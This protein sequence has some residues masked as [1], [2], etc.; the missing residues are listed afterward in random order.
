MRGD[1]HGI[2]S[3][4][5]NHD[6]QNSFPVLSSYEP[7]ELFG[8]IAER[9]KEAV[10]VSFYGAKAGAGCGVLLQ[11]GCMVSALGLPLPKR[12]S[13]SLQQF[14][15]PPALLIQLPP[16]T[17]SGV[18]SSCGNSSICTSDSHWASSS[19]SDFGARFWSWV[20]WWRTPASHPRYQQRWC[21]G[22]AVER[23]LY[24]FQLLS[25]AQICPAPQHL[26]VTSPTYLPHSLP[27]WPQ[28]QHPM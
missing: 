17:S 10:A 16:H 5:W 13:A 18:R 25:W 20:P 4:S 19:F 26:P 3:S 6:F 12:T 1:L 21:W 28:A 8:V 23:D 27:H 24:G 2:S 11:L 14:Q 15:W 9:W 7:Q 22:L